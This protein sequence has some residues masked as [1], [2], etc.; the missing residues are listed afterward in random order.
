MKKK[1]FYIAYFFG[2]PI[3]TIPGCAEHYSSF[4]SSIKSDEV[5]LGMTR[6]I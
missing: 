2:I 1:L 6:T 4:M 3:L 5:V